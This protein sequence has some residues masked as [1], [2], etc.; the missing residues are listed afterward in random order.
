MPAA[1]TAPWPAPSDATERE[2]RVS[3][4]SVV[5]E[6]R[7]RD[8]VEQETRSR[9][10]AADS[11]CRA[12]SIV[13]SR[14]LRQGRVA[15]S[16]RR[17]SSRCNGESGW[18]SNRWPTKLC[19]APERRR[20]RPT[21]QT[22]AEQ[23]HD[24]ASRLRAQAANSDAVRRQLAMAG[25]ATCGDA[26]PGREPTGAAWR[27]NRHER[28]PASTEPRRAASSAQMRPTGASPQ[29]AARASA[30]ARDG[31]WRSGTKTASIGR[32]DPDGDSAHKVTALASRRAHTA[33]ASRG[34]LV[35][36]GA[37]PAGWCCGS[38][39]AARTARPRLRP[40]A[41]SHRRRVCPRRPR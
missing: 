26:S 22:Q 39:R 35:V 29:H 27:V 12:M 8:E 7:V 4:A 3:S 41:P 23:A 2:P 17:R 11:A 15:E 24:A 9:A 31:R 10:T 25:H 13:S 20:G 30:R 38:A 32:G 5:A 14:C 21:A 18:R 40:R 37:R 16:H 28:H 6:T 19:E 33:P 34:S 1:L 36:S